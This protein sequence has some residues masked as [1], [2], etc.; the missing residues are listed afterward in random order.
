VRRDKGGENGTEKHRD[1]DDKPCNGKMV[2]A[3]PFQK[4]HIN[5]P[6][7]LK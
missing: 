3:D 1:K 2:F 7:N 6:I 5:L 4:L